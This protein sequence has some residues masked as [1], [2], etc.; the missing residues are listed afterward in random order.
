MFAPHE[1]RLS[2]PLLSKCL[3]RDP[4]RR[5]LGASCISRR[6]VDIALHRLGGH[7]TQT[8]VELQATSCRPSFAELMTWL[9]HGNRTPPSCT[10]AMAPQAQ[11]V[12][13]VSAASH[14]RYN[15]RATITG[16]RLFHHEGAAPCFSALSR[17]L[18]VF[19]H[20]ATSRV[21]LHRSSPDSAQ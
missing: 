1:P 16:C 9:I 14:S 18:L 6:V 17:L 4:S 15:Q 19:W 12:H 8:S 2:Q 3:H 5:L 13:F 21:Q 11:S 10:S 20:A 7:S